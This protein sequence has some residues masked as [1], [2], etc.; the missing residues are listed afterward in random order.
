[1]LS[2]PPNVGVPSRSV[3]APPSCLRGGRV[4]WRG[5]VCVVMSRLRIGCGTLRHPVP[6]RVILVSLSFACCRVCCG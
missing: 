4:E 5:V 3:L 1:M 6:S 2:L